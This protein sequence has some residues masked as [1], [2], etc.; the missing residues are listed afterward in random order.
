MSESKIDWESVSDR[1]LVDEVVD[2]GLWDQ[3]EEYYDTIA[4]A[5][6]SDLY[7]VLEARGFDMPSDPRLEQIWQACRGKDVPQVLADYLWDTI[8]KA[9]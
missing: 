4:S 6:S 5:S 8:G 7:E 3:F 9:I 1:E 2:R